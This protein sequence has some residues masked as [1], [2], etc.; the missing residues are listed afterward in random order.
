M[1][2]ETDQIRV[3][4]SGRMV[5]GVAGPELSRG[6]KVVPLADVWKAI[7]QRQAE[8]LQS[9]V[10]DQIV[11]LLVEP[12]SGKERAAIQVNLLDTVLTRSWLREAPTA[13]TV[14]G[15]F[16]LSGGTA[17]V[18]LAPRWRKGAG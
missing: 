18:W 17:G 16:L 4:R 13:W 6:H 15:A 7:E 3:D 14:L 5:I 8:A 1:K 12:G 10:A 9:L 2:I 11:L